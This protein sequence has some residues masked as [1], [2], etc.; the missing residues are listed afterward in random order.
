MIA[1]VL[2]AGSLALVQ[3]APSAEPPQLI[4]TN[5]VTGESTTRSMRPLA[6]LPASERRTVAA[7][8]DSLRNVLDASIASADKVRLSEV[9]VPS[10]LRGRSLRGAR[11]LPDGG[12]EIAVDSTGPSDADLAGRLAWA[13]W[14]TRRWQGQ[15]IQFS[16]D[17]ENVHDFRQG[18]RA[19]YVPQE[20][21]APFAVGRELYEADMDLKLYSL[22][23]QRDGAGGYR[24]MVAGPAGWRDRVAIAADLFAKGRRADDSTKTRFWIVCDTVLSSESDSAVRFDSTL[25]RVHA[26]RIAAAAG[27]TY[28]DVAEPDEGSVEYLRWFESNYALLALEHPELHAIR[29]NAKALALA[30]WMIARDVAPDERWTS[31]LLP[32]VD[33]F[34]SH[35][36]ALT[37]RD[38]I[39]TS[40]GTQR[41]VMDLVG[42]VEM[43]GA[44]VSRKDPEAADWRDAPSTSRHA[45][46]AP[47]AR[48]QAS[49]HRKTVSVRE[50]DDSWVPA[51]RR[52]KSDDLEYEV[53]RY[54]LPLSARDAKGRG[55]GFSTRSRKVVAAS[56]ITPDGPAQLTRNADGSLHLEY[57]GRSRWIQADWDAKGRRTA[58]W[59]YTPSTV[60]TP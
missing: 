35:G 18:S 31:A 50:I 7:L 5:P 51:P 40:S 15:K 33:S 54:G 17:P 20:G 32:V 26:R 1:S 21:T 6:A 10:P 2:L 60:E 34:V 16:L 42:G 39:R 55:I 47:A 53:S 56:A 4:E 24:R 8:A 11:L 23:Y 28:V 59:E 57:Q 25:V 12:V 14:F 48:A 58:L 19:V 41:I 36:P 29:E 22:G 52:V 44:M 37:R 43:D 38:T 9:Q 13:L 30:R 3:A 49:R 27:N 46:S 45:S